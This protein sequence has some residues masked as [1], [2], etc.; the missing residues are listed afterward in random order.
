[1]DTTVRSAYKGSAASKRAAAAAMVSS[2]KPPIKADPADGVDGT[3]YAFLQKYFNQGQQRA[4][5]PVAVAEPHADATWLARQLV[6]RRPRWAGIAIPAFFVHLVWWSYMLNHTESF[7]LFG[8]PEGDDEDGV[9]GYWASITMV[10]GSLVAGATSVGGGA[11]A[12]PVMTLALGVTPPVARDFSL[13]IQTVGMVAA[14]FTILYQQIRVDW[15]AIV[16][17]TLGG[18]IGCPLSLGLIAPHIPPPVT[19]M[20][21]VSTWFAFAV[22]LYLLNRNPERKTFAIIHNGPRFQTR[23]QLA[24]V[25]AGVVGGLLTGLAGSGMDITVFAVHTLYFRVSEKTATPTSVILMAVNT[26]VGF[27]FKAFWLEGGMAPQ[28]INF[29]L[30]CVPVVTFGAPIGSWLASYCHRLVLAWFVYICNTV[31]F[32]AAVVIVLWNGK[33]GYNVEL[34]IASGGVILT[35]AMFFCWLERLG[36]R[37][38][39]SSGEEQGQEGTG[40]AAAAAAATTAAA[41]GVTSP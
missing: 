7:A 26:T 32:A 25:L 1:V 21:F 34:A 41:A 28:A 38:V 8:E 35:Q 30:V 33:Y 10:F 6:W 19:K 29:W 13:M 27:F 36:R 2:G 39:A 12:F 3:L 9:A 15:Q 31:Q 40:P 14:T 18:M 23:H 11:V 37:S 16:W 20:A 4:V 5:L 24:L 22:A 17:C